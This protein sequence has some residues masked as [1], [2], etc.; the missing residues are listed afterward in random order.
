MNRAQAAK[1]ASEM[2][3]DIEGKVGEDPIAREKLNDMIDNCAELSIGMSMKLI[4]K[5][6]EE[7]SELFGSN[8]KNYSD[9]VYA[10]IMR[11]CNKKLRGV[12]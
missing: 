1:M 6:N 9:L 5:N 4:S 2:L 7:T 10:G 12:E 11:E 3:D 8:A